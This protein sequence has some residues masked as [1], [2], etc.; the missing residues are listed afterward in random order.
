[1]LTIVMLPGMDGSGAFFSPLIA[2]LGSSVATQVISYPTD[3]ALNYDQLIQLVEALLPKNSPFVLLGESFSGPIVVSVAAAK[4]A[5][6]QAIILV[7]TFV[8]SPI[9]IPKALRHIVCLFPIRLIPNNIVSRYLLG[10][11]ATKEM[12]AKLNIAMSRVYPKVWRERLLSILNVDVRK[13]LSEIDVPILTICATQDKIV[14]KSASAL[15]SSGKQGVVI[16]DIEGAHFI[17][18]TNPTAS[19]VS[20]LKFL[21]DFGI[22]H[23]AS[24]R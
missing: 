10:D 5:G 15:I 4:P 19:A 17:L 14:S 16:A 24:F 3:R 7:S 2:A 21:A 13:K 6:L 20:I 9:S 22:I 18:Q 8:R 1:M 12:A 23:S 11:Y